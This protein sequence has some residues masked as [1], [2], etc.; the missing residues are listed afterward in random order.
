MTGFE[1]ATIAQPQHQEN[2]GGELNVLYQKE[3]KSEKFWQRNKR[4][5]K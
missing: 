5:T 4:A 1:R 2:S 3:R